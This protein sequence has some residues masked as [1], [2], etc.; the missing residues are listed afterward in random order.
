MSRTRSCVRCGQH[1]EW[2]GATGLCL[3]C[4]S[5][6]AVT[7]PP[8]PQPVVLPTLQQAHQAAVEGREQAYEAVDDAW[9]DQAFAA[10]QR[11]AASGSRFCSNDLW[12]AGLPVPPS[13]NR[14]ALGGVLTRAARAG[15]IRKV[16]A[17]AVSLHGHGATNNSWWQGT[18]HR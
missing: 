13:G 3:P 14:R 6:K 1:V 16:G 10:V 11:L 7:A 15:L 5:G 12:A 17:G 4:L 2:R 18:Q 8:P 9:K